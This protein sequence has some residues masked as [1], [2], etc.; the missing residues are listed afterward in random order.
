MIAVL[1]EVW[2]AEGR[3]SDY[4]DIAGKL[5]PVLEAIDGFISVERFQS[6]SDPRKLLSLSYWRDEAAVTA[7]RR[8]SEHRLA[9]AQGRSQIFSDYRLRVA[10]VVRDYGLTDRAQAPADSRHAH[11]PEPA[12]AL[13]RPQSPRSERR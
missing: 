11:D 4:M 8:T 10:A 1:F 2:P 5:R 12:D 13:E 9:Q 3:D 7:W 6:L